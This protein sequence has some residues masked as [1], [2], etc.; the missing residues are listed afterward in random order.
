VASTP[1]VLF[2]DVACDVD[3]LTYGLIEFDQRDVIGGTSSAGSI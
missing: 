1:E 2:E 3:S